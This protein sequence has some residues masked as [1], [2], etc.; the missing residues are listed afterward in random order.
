MKLSPFVLDLAHDAK[1]GAYAKELV[2]TQIKLTDEEYQEKDPSLFYAHCITH[3][4]EEAPII[5]RKGEMLIGAA[6]LFESSQ[7]VIP[8]L[9]P[10]GNS[11]GSSLSH[12]T[13]G[14]EEIIHHG[15]K[16]I[17]KKVDRYSQINL[18]EKE[19]NFYKAANEVL[20]AFHIFH[21]RYLRELRKRIFLSQGKEKKDLEIVLEN[22]LT[23][24]ENPPCNFRQAI[25]SLL[26]V[27]IFERLCGNW[28]GVG[29]IDLMLGDFLDQDLK[30][31]TITE[32]EARDVI[33]CFLIRGCDWAI[34]DEN[35]NRGSGDAQHY[36]NIV[37]SGQDSNGYEIENS[38][39]RLILE[40]QAELLIS[41]WPIAV[42]ISSRSS[43]RLLRLIAEAEKKGSGTVAVYN[44]D[45]II[46][47][48]VRFGYPLEEARGF[49]ND[50]CWEIQ[51]PGKTCFCYH[52][53]DTLLLL[54]KLVLSETALSC[55]TMEDFYYEFYL[56]LA[57]QLKELNDMIDNAYLGGGNMLFSL[58][59]EGCIEK[60]REY[61][62]RGPKYSVASP[63]A[64][65]IPD[66]ANALSAIEKYVFIEKRISLP[67]IRNA[68]KNNWEGMESDR[69]LILNGTER[70]GA[71]GENNR[72]CYWASRVLHDFID[73]CQIKPLR[74]GVYRPAGVST[75]GREIV[76]R[77][78]RMATPDGHKKGE[79]LSTNFTPSPGS[80]KEGPT[81]MLLDHCGL[82][83]EGLTNGTA[84]DI[85]L[86]PKSLEGEKG[87][88]ALLALYRV[89]IK[90]GGIFL[91]I[92]A[93][94]EETLRE[95]QKHPEQYRS[96]SVRV[97]GWSARFVTLDTDW[98]DM[99]IGRVSRSL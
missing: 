9:D 42:R 80:D 33:A 37:L 79:I 11:V 14:F 63:H 36:Q 53:F 89:F 43:E 55:T 8:V 86:T 16:G 44:N 22:F 84:L 58:F 2:K 93:V 78:H 30:N 50:G 68:V 75:F 13:I 64:G 35:G 3:I 72:G 94:S 23:V 27:F 4:A 73:F 76:W 90:K 41:D 19:Q 52:P 46:D 20:D 48:L 85:K 7:H 49:A 15:L 83:L 38:V 69:L 74:A 70:Y 1:T 39:T 92:D 18:G 54:Q 61:A 51:I 12:T 67:E 60:G 28:P 77:S 24:P 29:R 59:T 6:T 47:N 5:I 65:G 98:Q 82:G 57:N 10:S 40:V 87:T 31:G 81:T 25:Q 45:F 32:Q 95:A 88:D 91:N 99:I 62:D 34:C 56:L 21:E 97:S 96:L 71:G 17:R 66:T 26:F